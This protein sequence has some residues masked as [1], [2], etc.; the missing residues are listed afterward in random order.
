MSWLS[1]LWDRNRNSVGNLVKNVAPAL[2]FVP[3]LGIPASFAAGAAGRAMQKGTNLGDILKS[4]ASNA[5]IG[6]GAR[7]LAGLAGFGGGGASAGHAANPV[8]RT[9]VQEAVP[10]SS[11]GVIAFGGQTFTPP[12]FTPPPF[13]PSSAAST[14]SPGWLS[15][16]AGFVKDNPD[17]IGHA[18]TAAANVYGGQQ[19]QG[20]Q[21]QQFDFQKQ[22]YEDEQQ[23]KRR[24]AELLAPLFQQIRAQQRPI[25]PNPY[26]MGQ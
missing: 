3:G 12:S 2:S 17:P 18:A 1:S 10:K 15:K 26:G 21:Q 4:G 19:Q 6:G 9:L 7:G 24:M 22:Q 23:R 16:A 20:M 11:N 25:A 14:S 8:G 5:A 13:V